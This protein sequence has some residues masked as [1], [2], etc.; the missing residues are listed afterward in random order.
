MVT[1]IKKGASKT[2]IKLLVKKTQKV[3]GIDALKYCG[4]IRLK[5]HPVLIQKRLR[6]EWE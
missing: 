3:T 1:V 5:E 2:S 6:D 4:V